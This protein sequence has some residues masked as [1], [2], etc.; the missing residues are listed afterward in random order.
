MRKLL[1][2]GL[3]ALRMSATVSNNVQ[4]DVRTTGNDA[5]GG[6]FVT[7]ATG[8]DFSQQNG[9]QFSGTD[10]ASSNGSTNPCTVTSA[11]HNFTAADV[12]NLL[13]ISAGT[14]WT[15][16]AG[17]RYQIVSVAANA[18]TL[19]RACGSVASLS[20]GTWAEGGAMATI[21]GAVAIADSTTTMQGGA[22]AGAIINIKSGV[23][24]VLT[25][26]VSVGANS[27][28]AFVGYNATHGDNGTCAT[29]TTATN[30]TNLFNISNRSYTFD[31]FCF[32]NT[33]VTPAIGLSIASGVDAA[34]RNSSFSGFTN[35]ISSAATWTTMIGIEVKNSTGVG[36]NL[37]GAQ[38][39][40]YGSYI[41]NNTGTNVVIGR[42]AVVNSIVS[43]GTT[44]GVQM[45]SSPSEGACINSDIANNG[46][47]GWNATT[48][49]FHMINCA[50]Y[51][52]TSAGVRGPNIGAVSNV[53]PVNLGEDNGYGGNTGGD[54]VGYTA[55]PGT[56]N[57][58]TAALGD[59]ALSV[60]P[61]VS[62][63]NFALNG[64]AGGGAALKAIGFPGTFPTGATVGT[65]NA[66]AV[67]TSSGGGGTTHAI[68]YGGGYTPP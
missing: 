62:A 53:M 8:T 24:Y 3:I 67:Q 38:G 40:L 31:N 65:L 32:T 26:A 19:D 59:V 37:S 35:G 60:S 34:I 66:G 64:S 9:S 68:G 1:L 4:F 11:G 56:M 6:G 10:L 48:A 7:G 41:H 18:A 22:G 16:G 55:A 63:T 23:N 44:H 30:S 33:A 50:I 17:V 47:D 15:T 14:N 28:I 12:G 51:G 58:T 46:G 57:G 5:N 36:V 29:V 54:R 42:G 39:I 27:N 20:G 45:N 61:F 13:N 2:L 52:N 21:A 43:A 25:S 49:T